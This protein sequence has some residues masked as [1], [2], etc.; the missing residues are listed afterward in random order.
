MPKPLLRGPRRPDPLPMSATFVVWAS[1]SDRGGLSPGEK[2]VWFHTWSMDRSFAD[3]CYMSSQATAAR[4]GFTQRTVEQHRYRL[5]K[6]GL[7]HRFTRE[8]R[9]PGWAPTLP[10][11][12]RPAGSR[13][14]GEEA[15][16]LAEQLDR[17][18]VRLDPAREPDGRPP[19]GNNHCKPGAMDIAPLM[20]QPLQNS[21]RA[22]AAALEGG[23][24]GG[25]LQ[26]HAVQGSETPLLPP[27]RQRRVAKA[28][29]ATTEASAP[30][31]SGPMQPLVQV[32]LGGK[33][34]PQSISELLPDAVSN[35]IPKAAAG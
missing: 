10:E 6:L 27:V 19:P 12:C 9:N 24:G 16:R 33:K 1:R 11:A 21:R 14:A 4:L 31:G 3:G 29:R 8:G 5:R 26:P 32:G 23:Q 17:Y 18:L 28:T 2:M 13:S 20:Q 7:L 22:K 35:L 15:I 34:G 25:V 30:G